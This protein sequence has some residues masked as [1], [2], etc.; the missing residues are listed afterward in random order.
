MNASQL[1]R[2]RSVGGIWVAGIER[3]DAIP[4]SDELQERLH[5]LGAM[6]HLLRFRQVRDVTPQ[7]D[8]H[9]QVGVAQLLSDEETRFGFGK[10]CTELLQSSRKR[11]LETAAC[12]SA[13][14][15]SGA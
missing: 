15:D 11:I 9:S 10:E 12:I 5:L 14:L 3:P 4:I 1:D 2:A 6:D 13:L 7:R 8:E